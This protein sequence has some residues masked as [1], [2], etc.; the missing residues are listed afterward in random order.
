MQQ[1]ANTQAQLEYS[2]EAAAFAA[3][4]TQQAINEANQRAAQS[5]THA[6]NIVSRA[7][8]T[9]VHAVA[10]SQIDANARV[11]QAEQAK[12]QA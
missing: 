12:L 1:V 9:A 8:E 6:M 2:F 11:L 4:I 5:E 10:A 3:P 7:R